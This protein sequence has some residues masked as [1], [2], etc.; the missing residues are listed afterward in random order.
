MPKDP[1]LI[2]MRRAFRQP[3]S[4]SL[5]SAPPTKTARDRKIID[6]DLAALERARKGTALAKRRFER[7]LTPQHPAGP[8][9]APMSG[10]RADRTATRKEAAT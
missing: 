8:E 9:A 5:K 4:C 10:G 2:P 1:T 3:S 6:D 7:A